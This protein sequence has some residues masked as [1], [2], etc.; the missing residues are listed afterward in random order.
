MCYISVFVVLGTLLDLPENLPVP[1]A[2]C[3]I[4]GA[5]A[6]LLAQSHLNIVEMMI[7]IL[8][9]SKIS[10]SMCASFQNPEL[11]RLQS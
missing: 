3:H 9:C 8:R 6:R 10:N 2:M 4:V 7:A 1:P 5:A 11:L